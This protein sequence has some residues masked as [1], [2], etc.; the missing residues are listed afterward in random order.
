MLFVFIV[1]IIKFFLKYILLYIKLDFSFIFKFLSIFLAKISFNSLYEFLF[2]LFVFKKL[3]FI[4]LFISKYHFLLIKSLLLSGFLFYFDLFFS[5]NLYIISFKIFV[6]KNY[7]KNLINSFV[8]YSSFFI[9]N[10][11]IIIN[12]FF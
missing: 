2:I 10:S 3:L 4:F 7:I 5:Q 6:N 11:L 12:H 9:I 1:N 8:Y